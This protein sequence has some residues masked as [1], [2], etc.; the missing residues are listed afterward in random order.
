[1]RLRNQ[2][3]ASNSS[4]C[5][6]TWWFDHRAWTLIVCCVAILLCHSA[7]ANTF[8]VVEGSA[9]S[10]SPNVCIQ[11]KSGDGVGGVDVSIYRRIENGERLFWR[12]STDGTGNVCPPAIPNGE[13]RIVAWIDTRDATLRLIVAKTEEKTV[14]LTMELVDR[15]RAVVAS[16]VAELERAP[17]RVWLKAFSGVVEDRTSAVIP[18][19]RVE[20]W[21]KDL[22]GDKAAFETQTGPAGQFSLPLKPGRYVAAIEGRGFRRCVFGFEIGER[23]WGGLQLTLPLWGQPQLDS[24][25]AEVRGK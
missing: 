13:Y 9:S 5:Q 7:F 19:V 11:L 3:A 17:L 24:D 14:P 21:Q 22:F 25:F 16:K 23:G 20:V 2:Y 10:D 8:V 6:S 4:S 15:D 18:N 1:M 12:T